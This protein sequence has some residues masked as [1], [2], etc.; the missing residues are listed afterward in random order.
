ML[1]KVEIKTNLVPFHFVY[2]PFPFQT[3]FIHLLILAI[4]F[5]VVIGEGPSVISGS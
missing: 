5:C 4:L 3:P 1:D 2:F